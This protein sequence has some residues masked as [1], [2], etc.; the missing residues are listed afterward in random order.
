MV[1]LLRVASQPSPPEIVIWTLVVEEGRNSILK[2]RFHLK[3]SVNNWHTEFCVLPL[4]RKMQK[5][6]K[7]LSHLPWAALV[8]LPH[9]NAD[10]DRAIIA[11][12]LRNCYVSGYGWRAYY[13]H[14]LFDPVRNTIKYEA[15]SHEVQGG[16][17]RKKANLDLKHDSAV[18]TLSRSSN[19]V[20]LSS[21]SKS[22]LVVVGERGEIPICSVYQFM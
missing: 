17:E 2:W 19:A 9:N 8:K 4:P 16:T 10:H 12:S 6:E 20:R 21:T 18:C 13:V 14:H 5:E 7:D 22:A 1:S 11:R 3:N 15:V